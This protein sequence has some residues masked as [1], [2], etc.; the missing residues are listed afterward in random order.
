MTLTGRMGQINLRTST[1]LR[2]TAA[3]KSPEAVMASLVIV[4]LVTVAA[5]I[6]LG[7]YCAICFAISREDRVRGSLRA[8]AASRSA[9]SARVLIGIGSKLN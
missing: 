9:R 2:E 4:A 1:G 3:E 5:G 7:A 8:D 6:L